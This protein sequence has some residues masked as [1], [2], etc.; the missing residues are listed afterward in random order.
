MSPTPL[1]RIERKE[2]LEQRPAERKKLAG[3]QEVLSDLL[4]IGT[5]SSAGLV[6]NDPVAAEHH[7]ALKFANG[8]FLLQ[9][10]ANST[11]TFLNGAR[12]EGEEAVQAGDRIALGVSVIELVDGGAPG[13]LSLHV[14]EGAFFFAKK[15]R[16]E[17]ESDADEWVRSE[18]T[19]GRM[20][21]LRRLNA[22]G[23]V[24]AICA[25]AWLWFS[26]AGETALQPGHLSAV[27]AAL[28]S[29]TPP[30][31]AHLAYAVEIAQEQGCAACHNSFDQPG[32][33]QCASCHGDL[34]DLAAAKRAHPF[35]S[36]A[37]LE[38]SQ[39]HREHHGATPPPGAMHPL[40]ITQNCQDCHGT[41]FEDEAGL[42][43]GLAKALEDF[44]LAPTSAAPVARL[45]SF[46]FEAFDHGRHH[47]VD[48]C[49]ACH[50]GVEEDAGAQLA[51]ASG[52]TSGPDFGAVTYDS[53]ME[54]HRAGGTPD[55][56]AAWI[57][58]D[59][60]RWNMDW[61]GSGDGEANCLA[62]HAEPFAAPLAMTSQIPPATALF[63]I[64]T[65]AHTDQFHGQES[66]GDCSTCHKAPD[67][68]W[69]DRT[70]EGRPFRHEQHLSPLIAGDADSLALVQSQ[71]VECHV[72]MADSAHL[73]TAPD[74]YVGPSV[75]SCQ[76]C[77]VDADTPLLT[78]PG[79]VTAPADAVLSAA[80][81][82]N[83]HMEVEG[84]CFACH[85]LAESGA[86]LM[87]T[88]AEATTCVQC[89]VQA[90]G[91]LTLAHAAIGGGDE[92]SCSGCHKP[93]GQASPDAPMAAVFYGPGT[94]SSKPSTF[95]H[96]LE[97]HQGATCQE[98][99]GTPAEGSDI[100][101]PPESAAQCRECHAANRFHWK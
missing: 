72:D 81:P 38:C 16:G 23:I 40:D 50:K 10:M 6:L 11:G 3:V 24:G 70:L 31:D 77:H 54:C 35:E 97:A 80:F 85:S 25:A 45:A 43:E 53:C 87:T 21:A 27:H 73:T 91:E 59:E 51:S 36:G 83:S 47:M 95:P 84:G 58:A 89:H 62:C 98:C 61:H 42:R 64:K 34:V 33:T 68:L 79:V 28:F 74:A 90:E 22:V 4:I 44:D 17:F 37:A 41:D 96:F 48:D 7:C 75:V 94:A 78:E 46:G 55:L 93:R 52:L 69:K 65:R 57:P 5:R 86:G 82:H 26:S 9:D 71:C 15:K 18:V 100:Y 14:R 8:R 76:T 12:V 29:E 19:F 30:T 88:S 2:T 92:Q 49:A 99:H 20:T 101:S 13:E 67:L 1:Y 56:P 66:P 60:F 32:V 63:S 39:C